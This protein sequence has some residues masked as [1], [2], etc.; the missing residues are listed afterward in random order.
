M[1]KNKTEK[2]I[3]EDLDMTDLEDFEELDD[4]ETLDEGLNEVQSVDTVND[5]VFKCNICGNISK[6]G[7]ELKRHTATHTGFPC[8]I[9]K[10]V[11][12][13]KDNLKKHQI[14]SHSKEEISQSGPSQ[15]QSKIEDPKEIRNVSP[16]KAA[17]VEG[18]VAGKKF[19]CEKCGQ[20]FEMYNIYLLHKLKHRET[21]QPNNCEVCSTLFSSRGNLI[22]HINRKHKDGSANSTVDPFKKPQDSNNMGDTVKNSLSNGLSDLAN[23]S[24]KEQE[25]R[26]ETVTEALHNPESRDE[27]AV[28][29]KCFQCKAEFLTSL[30]L[31]KHK[32][33]TRHQIYPPQGELGLAAN[34]KQEIVDVNNIK[35][36]VFKGTGEDVKNIKKENSLMDNDSEI[37]RNRHASK[38]SGETDSKITGDAD[39]KIECKV[40]KKVFRTRKLLSGHNSK[41]H[42]PKPYACEDCPKAFVDWL[43]LRRHAY[44]Y[45][46]ANAKKTLDLLT[47]KTPETVAS[48]PKTD[49]EMTSLNEEEKEAAELKRKISEVLD[50][51]DILMDKSGMNSSRKRIGVD[52]TNQDETVSF[53]SILAN[54]MAK[55]N[56]S[57]EN[58]DEVDLDTE[59]SLECNI[60]DKLFESSAKLK[61]H[62]VIHNGD[63][64]YACD[65][66]ESAFNQKANLK[67][68]KK[69]CHE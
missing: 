67:R 53:Q 42:T 43:N 48:V 34:I 28:S 30:Q 19:N 36:E 3:T 22:K 69:S 29:H 2:L 55:K 11:Y 25:N 35:K 62:K 4:E 9:C 7:S 38:I 52:K 61:R 10:M 66:C 65:V 59:E 47:K 32:S 16:I 50:E 6:S 27:K 24:V 46:P 23:N 37:E 39:S 56:D 51:E 17:N 13:R 60:C 63:K 15:L 41:I 44:Q 12:T 58:I 26:S 33:N 20:E 45:H 68:H 21:Y 18:N 64:P 8:N 14:N 40:C 57:E 49:S 1:E 5:D 54:A 31:K